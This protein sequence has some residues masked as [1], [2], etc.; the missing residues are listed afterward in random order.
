MAQGGDPNTKPGGTGSPGMGD[1]GYTIADETGRDD[2]RNH[3]TGSL[4][5]ANSGPPNTGGCQFFITVTPTPHLDGKHT[6]FGRV[7]DGLDVARAL[8]QDDVIELVSVTRRRDHEYLP[9]M[10][11]KVITNTQL[12]S[13][14]VVPPPGV[15]PVPTTDPAPDPAPQREET[16]EPEVT[17]EPQ[18]E[19]TPVS[20]ESQ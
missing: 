14:P 5:M 4:S 1:P 7:I 2:H 19:E 3:F 16:P 8:K 6:V 11:P 15:D 12:E 18:S 10:I 9:T 20:P 17:P 13:I